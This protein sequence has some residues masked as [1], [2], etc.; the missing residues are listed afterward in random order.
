[1]AKVIKGNFGDKKD[2][3]PAK[4]PKLTKPTKGARKTGKD[5]IYQLKIT[6]VGSDPE[7]WRRVLVSGKTSLGE[8]HSIIQFAMDWTDMHLHQFVVKG[9]AYEDP[10]PDMDISDAKDENKAMLFD[11]APV[12]RSSF[13]YIYDFGD[14]WEHKIKV[15]KRL[16][17]HEIFEG[18]PVCLEGEG[19]CPPEDCGGIYGYYEMLHILDDPEDEEYE[20]ILGWIG[21]EFDPNDF[22]L[23]WTNQL[24]R[25]IR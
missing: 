18:R 10:N 23:E 19:A 8:L 20:N 25:T 12:A 22:D 4:S 15:E 2:Q 21:E 6:L 17:R 7:I 16:D 5:K 11:I 14:Y 24:L 13:M 1:M 3:K 9:V